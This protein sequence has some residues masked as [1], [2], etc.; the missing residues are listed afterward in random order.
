M[1]CYRSI[2]K[3]ELAKLML[4]IPITGTWSKG[5]HKECG[6]SGYFGNVVC[7]FEDQVQWSDPEHTIFLE[8]EI[9]ESRIVER[10]ESVWMMPKTFAKTKVYRGRSGDE[11]YHLSEI[12]FKEYDIRDVVR[13]I[14]TIAPTMHM[15]YILDETYRYHT[16][17][18]PHFNH[19][20]MT[21]EDY[22]AEFDKIIQIFPESKTA[23]PKSEYISN[24][25]R[26]LQTILDI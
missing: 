9:P 17:C 10:A 2:N 21:N 15:G 3:Y 23:I 22:I 4:G 13:V 16:H 26:V 19:K 8:L 20:S 11:E 18:C 7:A 14:T 1:K 24:A 6:Y 25:H 12:F 5:W